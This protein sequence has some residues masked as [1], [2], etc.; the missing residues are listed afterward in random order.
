MGLRSLKQA[1]Q[2]LLHLQVRLVAPCKRCSPIPIATWSLTAAEWAFALVASTVPQVLERIA[3]CK[4][5]MALVT[6]LLSQVNSKMQ[7]SQINS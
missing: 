3:T 4:K 1:T 5:D 2:S 6:T 7:R